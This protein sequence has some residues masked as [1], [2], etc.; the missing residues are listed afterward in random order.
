[1]AVTIK[2]IA[3]HTGV[4]PST[5]S[6]VMNNNPSISKE[7]RER[8]LKAIQELGY[9]QAASQESQPAVTIKNIGVIL[10]PSAQDAY[11][12]TFYLKAIRGIS[13]ICNQRHTYT[14]IVTGEDYEEILQSVRIL[15]RSGRVDGF[16]ILYSRKNDIVVDYLCEH[17]LLY[18]IV[19]KPSDLASQTICVDNDNLLAS[20]E[21]TDY[22][23]ALGHR[24]IGFIGGETDFMHASDRRDGYQ[25]SLLLHGLSVNH[26]YCIEMEGIYSSGYQKLIHLLQ[27]P[28]RPTAFIVS[29]DLLA[30]ALERVCAHVGLSIPKDVSIIAFNNSLYAQLASPQLTAV[31]INSYSLGR[32]AANQILNHAENPNLSATKIIVP[33]DIVER[34]SCKAICE[35]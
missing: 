20:R 32:E 7:T 8:V 24:R 9:E 18:V 21:A 35:E 11:E 19:G 6:R 12:N 16:I 5:V 2:D 25:L 29:D 27:R 34:K 22:L 10:P 1:M 23:Y 28:D 17:G 33:H 13:Q 26:D 30:L 4:S 31:D 3:K 14:C 15:H